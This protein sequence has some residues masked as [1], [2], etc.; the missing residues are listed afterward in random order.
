MRRD[1]GQRNIR[2]R[3]PSRQ[4][5]SRLLI[6]VSDDSHRMGQDEEDRVLCEFCVCSS[7]PME[8]AR[9]AREGQPGGCWTPRR[10][11]PGVTLWSQIRRRPCRVL[12]EIT[13]ASQ[14][15]P[16]AAFS[17]Y[18]IWVIRG[19]GRLPLITRFG[20]QA[21]S[22]SFS[23]FR[24]TASCQLQLVTLGRADGDGE[25]DT[26]DSQRAEM[27]T[28]CGGSLAGPV[29]VVTSRCWHPAG[30]SCRCRAGIGP[31]AR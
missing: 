31:G 5:E 30:A 20:A 16:R 12:S 2:P 8:L 22:S 19:N 18:G 25:P 6:R 24:D 11:E 23:S 21:G 9:S 28:A 3:E 15:A 29:A 17:Q 13:Y 26:P 14:V 7:G 10:S 4:H 27:T 1:P